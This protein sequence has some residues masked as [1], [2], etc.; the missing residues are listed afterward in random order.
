MNKAILP[1]LLTI[2]ARFLLCRPLV[3]GNSVDNSVTNQTSHPY[4]TSACHVRTPSY[5]TIVFHINSEETSSFR[6]VTWKR[7]CR[8]VTSDASLKLSANF[9]SS[10]TARCGSSV[11][12]HERDHSS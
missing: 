1:L 12:C 11:P 7:S 2:I 3:H 5:F 8:D 6:G 9:A 4:K 10:R